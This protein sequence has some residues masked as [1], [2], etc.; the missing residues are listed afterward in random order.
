MKITPYFIYLDTKILGAARQIVTF[1]DNGVFSIDT[2]VVLIKKY[3]HSSAKQIAKIFQN[4][5]VRYKF[6]NAADLDSLESGVV[7][8][9]F[10]AQSNTRVVAN[11]RL[12]HI[13]ITHGES[14]KLASVKP[15]IRIYDHVIT[16]GQA[17]IDRFLLHKVFS[18]ADINSGRL[19]PMGNTFIGKTG[20]SEVK[21]G[22]KAIVYA[23]TWEGGVEQENYSSL[24]YIEYVTQTIMQ[25]SEH[26]D[27]KT[28]VIKPHPNTGHRLKEYNQHLLKIIDFF[29]THQFEVIVFKP[30]FYVSFGLHWWLKRKGVKFKLKLD[31]YLAVMG[32]CD[33]SAIETQFLN[34]DIAY[35][36]FCNAAQKTY[37][38]NLRCGEYYIS[39]ALDFT[40]GYKP[41]I[42]NS[43]KEFERLKQYVIDERL[44]V[45][46]I[47]QRVSYLLDNLYDK[48]DY[49]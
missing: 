32:F 38:R 45:V 19:I 16:A 7:F 18:R 1:F 30:H 29:L 49:S 20:F 42:I 43:S 14:N 31:E 48:S 21:L 5:N 23:P 41:I 11:R 33:V 35:Y 27:V 37:L 12:K 24:P 40:E 36:L 25:A 39:H 2:T 22:R 9:P 6:V 17:G 46:S 15:I 10:N 28:I 47:S 8:Y 26:F 34:E 13:F 3:K 44:S 4:G